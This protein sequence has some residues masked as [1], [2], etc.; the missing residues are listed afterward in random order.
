MNDNNPSNT[1]HGRLVLTV[2]V[3]TPEEAFDELE[4]RF[5]ALDEGERPEPTHEVV[6]PSERD[7]NRLLNPNNV[8][9]LRTI[10][11]ESPASIRETARL[12]DR[13]VRQVHDNLK[14]LE[15]LNLVRFE[16]DGRA[17]RP[18]VWY[19]DIDV[20]LPITEEDISGAPA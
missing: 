16:R 17:M 7:I 11:R 14:E 20:E 13:D 12:V 1:D 15:Q 5:A 18:V 2:R 8:E 10:A 19:D 9:L 6:L 4:D 3:A